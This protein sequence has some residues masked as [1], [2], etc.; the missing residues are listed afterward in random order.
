MALRIG[1]V[2]GSSGCAIRACVRI[3]TVVFEGFAFILVGYK[4][5]MHARELSD[6]KGITRKSIM[7]IVFRD[8]LEYVIV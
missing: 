6:T 1:C 4:A 3:P 7:N 5:F 2:L 8:S